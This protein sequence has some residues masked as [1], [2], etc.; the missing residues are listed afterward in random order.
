MYIMDFKPIMSTLLMLLTTTLYGQSIVIEGTIRQPQLGV[1]LNLLVLEG[2]VGHSIQRDTL[3]SHHFRF[4]VTPTDTTLQCYLLMCRNGRDYTMPLKLWAKPGTHI[5]IEAD[6]MNTASWQ[7]QSTEPAQQTYNAITKASSKEK[8]ELNGIRQMQRALSQKVR[9]R[10]DW[11]EEQ[12]QQFRVQRDSLEHLDDSLNL[13]ISSHTLQCMKLLPRDTVWMEE[14]YQRTRWATYQENCPY[15]TIVETLYQRLS[16]ELKYSE[17]GKQINLLLYPP[18]RF[19]IGD[20]LSDISFI[21]LEG[22][23]KKLSDFEGK[24]LLL[25]FW[26]SGCG[27]CIQSFAETKE[28]H[29]TYANRLHI[30]TVSI[31]QD[32]TWKAAVAKH[33]L[34]GLNLRDPNGSAGMLTRFGGNGIPFYVLIDTEGKLVTTWFGYT[35]GSLRK[36]LETFMNQEKR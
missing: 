6:H 2:E 34:N 10:S 13:C 21:T 14:L 3:R 36:K 22:K 9:S 5:R 32:K 12:M 11:S 20:R 24:P 4:E 15:K 7:A 27:P 1:C 18:K 28:L 8:D 17:R 16:P 31:D 33:A 35:K 30:V 19:E 25:D 26:S 29:Q 23:Q